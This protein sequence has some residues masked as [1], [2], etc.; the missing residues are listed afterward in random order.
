MKTIRHYIFPICFFGFLLHSCL[1]SRE[2]DVP[3]SAVCSCLPPVVS[4]T[5]EVEKEKLSLE[6]KER[7]Q[8]FMLCLSKV[9]AE[10]KLYFDYK[11]KPKEK[12]ILKIKQYYNDLKSACP[13]AVEFLK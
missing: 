6:W 7:K 9:D 11:E 1:L 5:K 13:E 8:Q 10:K 3:I 12:R 4:N 2:I